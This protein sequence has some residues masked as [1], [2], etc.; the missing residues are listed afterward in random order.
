MENA[1]VLLV[2]P[3]SPLIIWG[4]GETIFMALLFFFRPHSCAAFV[5]DLLRVGCCD[6]VNGGKIVL[7]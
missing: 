5:M 4:H 2:F 1:A 3:E 6:Q 7:E